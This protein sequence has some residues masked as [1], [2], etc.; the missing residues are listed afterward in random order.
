MSDAWWVVV[1]FAVVGL[2]LL[3]AV[4]RCGERLG[5]SLYERTKR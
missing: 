3:V 2:P 1:V 4:G 5:R